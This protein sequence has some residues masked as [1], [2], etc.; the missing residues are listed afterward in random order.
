M[1]RKDI[2][3][4]ILQTAGERGP[5][6]STC[7]SEIA[8]ILFPEDWRKQMEAVRD[9]AISLH[10]EARV[11]LSQKGKAVDPDHFKGPIRIKIC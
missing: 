2:R 8:R 5:L 1:Q 10:K 3:Q 4:T 6:K 9:A 7:P 11:V